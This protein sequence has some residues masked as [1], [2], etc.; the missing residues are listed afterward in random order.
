MSAL[1]ELLERVE[2]ATG[3]DR[4]IDAAIWLQMVPGATR[5]QWSYVHARTNR[6]CSVDETRDAG[7]LIIVPAYTASID[8]A[9][10]LVE[11]M[12][13]MGTWSLYNSDPKCIPK[14]GSAYIFADSDDE[15]SFRAAG[16]TPALALIA[17]LLKAMI[18]SKP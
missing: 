8:A 7:R 10:G 13:P 6:V 18:A 3:P 1:Q 5:K 15:D 12:L 9:V 11:R 17:A 16:A 14:G 2:A 4:E